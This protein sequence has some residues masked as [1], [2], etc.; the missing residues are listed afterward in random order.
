MAKGLKKENINGIKLN[1]LDNLFGPDATDK[2]DTKQMVPLKQ[3]V[4]FKG[5]PFHVIENTELESLAESVRENGVIE[6]L[7]VRPKSATKFEIISGHRRK[8]AAEL[9]GLQEVPVVVSP[10]D[11]D[12]ATIL[13]VD[14][15]LHRESILP[16]EKA[17]AYKMKNEA[18]R[19]QGKKTA[20]SSSTAK[21]VGEGNGDSERTVHRYIQLTNLIPDLLD[22]VDNK[23]I[24]LVNGAGLSSLKENEQNDILEYAKE[25][26]KLPDS[27]QVSKLKEYS[28]NGQWSK[29][30]F[31][32]VM[33]EKKPA[34]PKIVINTKKLHEY[35]PENTTQ[36]EMETI[37]FNLLDNWKEANQ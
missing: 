18:M 20:N 2:D 1:G 25:T 28:A 6:P 5:H 27:G 12:Q 34:K 30:L 8:R 33:G 3:L 9:A 7:L 4:S 17:F 14:S 36:E 13:M 21:I 31:L 26:G 35:F 16:S 10:L 32:E 19:H 23:A 15:N 37:I 29:T 24:S 22:M 11:D